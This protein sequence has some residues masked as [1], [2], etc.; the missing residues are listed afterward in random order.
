MVLRSKL[1]REVADLSHRLNLVQGEIQLA[2]AKYD[3]PGSK[4]MRSKRKGDEGPETYLFLLMAP[5]VSAYQ[6]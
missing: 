3:I 6:K 2:V 4:V 5:L 1:G